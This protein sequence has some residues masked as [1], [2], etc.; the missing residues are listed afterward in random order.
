[1]DWKKLPKNIP[2][3]DTVG[4]LMQEL[5]KLPPELPIKLSFEDGVKPVVYNAK[6]D[7]RHL[8]FEENEGG[9]DD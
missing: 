8:S 7:D 5:A 1:M 3:C 4:E 2:A 9:D 6:Y